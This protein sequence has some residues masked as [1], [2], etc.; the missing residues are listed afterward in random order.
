[1][2]MHTPP[3][4]PGQAILQYDDGDYTIMRPGKFVICAVSGKQI[5]LEALK[6]WNPRTQQAF[7]G[8]EEAMTSWQAL[9]R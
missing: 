2:N 4:L 8:P 9:N 3:P 6:Y 1:M 7:A 5:P